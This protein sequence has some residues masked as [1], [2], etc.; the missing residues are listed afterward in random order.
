MIVLYYLA[1]E[2]RWRLWTTMVV[3]IKEETKQAIKLVD[4]EWNFGQRKNKPSA[5]DQ[6]KGAMVKGVARSMKYCIK[7]KGVRE[8]L[9][10]SN[11]SVKVI[12]TGTTSLTRRRVYKKKAYYIILYWIKWL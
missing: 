3:V 6:T 5:T 9:L 1:Q 2:D 7:N 11:L 4:K 8:V 10:F 12:G